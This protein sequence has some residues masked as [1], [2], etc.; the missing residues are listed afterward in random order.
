[1]DG[2]TEVMVEAVGVNAPVIVRST[3]VGKGV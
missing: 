2:T 1:M 3:S